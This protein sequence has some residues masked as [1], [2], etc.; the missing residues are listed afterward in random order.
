MIMLHAIT[1]H[2]PLTAINANG[3]PI[4]ENFFKP[5]ANGKGKKGK[6]AV[7]T[8]NTA[9]MLWQAKS[10]TGDYHD[11]MTEGM[12]MEWLKNC[13]APAFEA[14]FGKNKMILVQRIITLRV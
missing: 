14:A 10:S 2:G 3:F 12:F 5:K 13:L 8:K 4:P 1:K 9:G 11:A 7:V 6:R